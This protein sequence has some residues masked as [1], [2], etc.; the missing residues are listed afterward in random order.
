MPPVN[1]ENPENPENLSLEEIVMRKASAR[2]LEDEFAPQSLDTSPWQ[3]VGY[4][5]S[6]ALKIIELMHTNGAIRKLGNDGTQ[7]KTDNV[8]SNKSN[9]H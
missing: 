6:T 2:L 8:K 1:P 7:E 5:R 9:S 4:S 3:C